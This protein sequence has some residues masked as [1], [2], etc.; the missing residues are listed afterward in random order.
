MKF[1]EL[2]RSMVE[3]LGVLAII[4]VLS[5]GAISGYSKV[6]FKYR[7]NNAIY[8]NQSIIHLIIYYANNLPYSNTENTSIYHLIPLF[9]KLNLIPENKTERNNEIFYDSLNNQNYV[10]TTLNAS[11]SIIY[12][13]NWKNGNGT[14]A[15]QFCTQYLSMLQNYYDNLQKLE[16]FYTSSEVKRFKGAMSQHLTYPDMKQLNTITDCQPSLYSIIIYLK[17]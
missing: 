16:I 9:V 4:G 8:E 17:H 15:S 10:Y 1:N 12:Q 14:E 2:G 3:M 6:M 13:I 11:D 5:V 7:L